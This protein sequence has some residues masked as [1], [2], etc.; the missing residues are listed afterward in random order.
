MSSFG[1]GA[2]AVLS[3]ESGEVEVL[4]GVLALIDD[5]S[6]GEEVVGEDSA[7]VVEGVEGL[8]LLGVVGEVVVD[9][10][11]VL[12]AGLVAGAT[13]AIVVDVGAGVV[14]FTSFVFP[15]LK[16]ASL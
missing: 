15:V 8:A 14:V 1:L 11:S 12:A 16:S 5:E 2:E 3:D 6:V 10:L 4:V 7:P 9:L 13:L